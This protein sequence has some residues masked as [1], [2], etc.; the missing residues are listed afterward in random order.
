MSEMNLEQV[1]ARWNEVLDLLLERD[2]ITWLAYFDAHLL[3]LEGNILTI[4]FLDPDKFLNRHDY[5]SVRTS[6]MMEQLISCASEVFGIDLLIQEKD[7]A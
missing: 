1:K 6:A 7:L 4:T 5:R 2:R 3:C